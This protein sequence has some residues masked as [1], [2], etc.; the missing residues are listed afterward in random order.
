[1][2][3]N[4]SLRIG[5]VGLGLIG[6]SLA[7]V[8]FE[9]GY[10]IYGIAFS[11]NTLNKARE[12][13]IFQEVSQNYSILDG[14]DIIFVAT[15]IN[16]IK[17]TFEK[18]SQ[19]VFKPCIVSDAASIKG[20]IVELAIKIFDPEIITFIAGHPM[21]GTEFKGID[22]AYSELFDGCRWVLCPINPSKKNAL[23]LL[24]DVIE[25]T[26][27]TIV[28]ANP[29]IHDMAV[30]LISHM[31]LLVSMGLVETIDSQ[32][33][34]VLK[35]LAFYLAASGFRDTTRIAGG[36][37]ELSYD[38]L[39]YNNKNVLKALDLFIDSLNKLRETINQDEEETLQ[40]F[41]EI[42]NL[43]KNLYSQ[44]GKNVFSGLSG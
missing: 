10:S 12:L 14:C 18:I 11:D 19:N 30:A 44:Y 4:E 15:P 17:D 20:D 38:M 27:S 9:H 31:P 8:L 3:D 1:M 26:G 33:D 29:Y 6:G 21:A 42:S 34:F 22:N 7:K 23:K 35:E 13:N 43:R 25:K 32:E 28:F 24:T 41:S 16:T 37:P 36:N 40:K 2:Q 5:I 39:K